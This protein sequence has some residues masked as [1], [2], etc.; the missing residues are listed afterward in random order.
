MTDPDPKM[1][2]LTMGLRFIQLGSDIVAGRLKAL[3]EAR[4]LA[5]DIIAAAAPV[6]VLAPH[7]S[8][9]GKAVAESIADAAEAIKFEGQ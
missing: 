2:S 3:E 4:K 1:L 9:D 8:E 7:L 5:E 6:D